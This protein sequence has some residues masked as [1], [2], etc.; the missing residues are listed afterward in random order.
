MGTE[1][2]LGNFIGNSHRWLQRVVVFFSA[3]AV[4]LKWEAGQHTMT[5]TY[6]SIDSLG[7]NYYSSLIFQ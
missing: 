5:P 7:I 1:M 3:A 6:T 2:Q 4:I